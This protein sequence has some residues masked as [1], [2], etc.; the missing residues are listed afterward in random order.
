MNQ[1]KMWN[2]RVASKITTSAQMW[3]EISGG[4]QIESDYWEIERE[5]NSSG[6]WERMISGRVR[7]S[8]RVWEST[9]AK[10]PA[11]E[12]TRVQLDSR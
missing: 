6:W 1:K 5:G 8:A 4:L 2:F 10:T 11:N 7:I 12:S 3:V 9:L